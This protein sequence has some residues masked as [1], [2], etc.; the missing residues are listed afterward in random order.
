[1]TSL[2][3][4]IV[5]TGLSSGIG[6]EV[7]KQLLEQAVPYSVIL[8]ARDVE[9]A[10]DAVSRLQYD[11][12][13]NAVTALPVE[14]ADLRTVKTF[15]Q[16]ALD[17][18]GSGKI[19]Y[20]LLNAGMLKP[21]EKGSH[22]KWCEA[23]VVNHFCESVSFVSTWSVESGYVWPV[24]WLSVCIFISSALFDT[25]AAGQVGCVQVANRGS[26][27]GCYSQ[28]ARCWYVRFALP[29]GTD[30]G[31]QRSGRAGWLTDGIAA[32][33]ARLANGSG[34]DG[35]SVYAGSK[36]AQLLAA[37][38]WRRQLKGQCDVVAV[39]PGLVPATGLGRGQGFAISPDLPDA[40]SVPE[41]AQSVIAAL[42][43][44]D[45]PEDP[46]RIFL[47]SWGEWWDRDVIG[48]TLD[49]ELQDS[50]CPG[51]EELERDAGVVS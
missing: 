5:A 19:D 35:Y 21:A 17:R 46:D 50:W 27:L 33:E 1:M 3:K 22:G 23:A 24:T 37:H 10:R 30:P 20:L 18:V 41:G 13:A 8:G 32:L 4:T 47:T 49:K 28:R 14:L 38:W 43:R 11:R 15:A 40:K 36:F 9:A 34:A 29:V 31:A 12:A 44:G 6:L 7:L 2:A 45:F 25:P 42:S 16:Q 26:F 48:K 39:S 51:R